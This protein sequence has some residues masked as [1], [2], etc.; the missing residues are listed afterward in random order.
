[1]LGGKAGAGQLLLGCSMWVSGESVGCSLSNAWGCLCFVPPPP[2]PP[3]LC[4]WKS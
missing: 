1:M 3:S 4:S 2:P